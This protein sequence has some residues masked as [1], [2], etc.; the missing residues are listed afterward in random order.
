MTVM[1]MPAHLRKPSRT[2]RYA[3]ASGLLLLAAPALSQD[4]DPKDCEAGETSASVIRACTTWLAIPNLDAATRGKIFYL[5]GTAW[6]KEQEPGVAVEDLTDAI[7]IDPKNADALKS[8]A[9]AHTVLGEHVNAA[10][11]WGL[12]IALQPADEEALL[13]RGA[14]HLAAN[15]TSE[16]L[17]DYNKVSELNAKNIDAYIGRAK[18]F[19][20]MNDREKTLKEF[21]AALAIDPNNLPIY[22]ARAELADRWGETQLAVESYLTAL[23]LNGMNLKARQALQRLGVYTPPN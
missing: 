8:R 23:R 20:R 12:V 19:D 14:S 1:M 3:V 21:T 16:A 22:I 4:F 9:R 18:T 5:R 2:W 10:E 15:K 7:K 6:L 13:L 11:D 17:G